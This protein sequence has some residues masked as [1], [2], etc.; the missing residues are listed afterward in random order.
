M[1]SNALNLSLFKRRPKPWAIVGRT[2]CS[3]GFDCLLAARGVVEELW[4][5]APLGAEA[6]LDVPVRVEARLAMLRAYP[7]QF[8]A[9]DLSK[10]PIATRPTESL[11]LVG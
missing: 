8:V 10:D 6:T 1:T 7:S 4:T 2:E 5:M 3:A 9:E 11:V